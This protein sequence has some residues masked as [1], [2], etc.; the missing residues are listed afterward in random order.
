MAYGQ[1]SV[2]VGT[3]QSNGFIIPIDEGVGGILF[4]LSGFETPFAQ[5]PLLQMSFGDGSVQLIHNLIEASGLGL[6][7]NDFM[8]GV[9]YYHISQFYDFVGKDAPLYIAFVDCTENFD[10]VER[11]QTVTSGKMFQLG[12]WTAQQLW[13]I[14]DNALK[15]TQLIPDVQSAAELVC[16]KIGESSLSPTPLSIIL[17]PNTNHIEATKIKPRK[18]PSAYTFEAPKVSVLL[19]QNGS[20]EVHAMQEMNPDKAPV[21]SIGLMMAVLHIAGAEE[22]VGAVM[23]YNLNKNDRFTN[24]ELGFG[25]NYLPLAEVNNVIRSLIAACGYIIPTSYDGREDEYFFSSDS[26]VS[27][28][29]YLSI[30]NNRVIHKCRRIVYSALLPYV[31]DDGLLNEK[32]NG[33]SIVTESQITSDV[34]DMLTSGMVNKRGYAQ[35]NGKSFSILDDENIIKDDAIVFEFRVTP[36][37]YNNSLK[38]TVL[39]Q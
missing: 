12:I 8:N 33:I 38:D 4:D 3:P 11:M 25:V 28:G 17:S 30:A 36:V 16:G 39:A 2:D 6:A 23:F 22:N 19:C 34:M 21:G 7:D 15:L 35:I 9:P 10:Y 31:N 14:N 32:G 1:V 20:D 13:T 29:D 37:N 26:T 18:L 5:Y 24:P 27:E